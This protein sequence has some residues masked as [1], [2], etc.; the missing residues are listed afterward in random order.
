MRRY[1]L[2]VLAV[3]AV[4]SLACGGS[5]SPK[6]TATPRPTATNTPTPAPPTA[7]PV[8]L[9]PVDQLRADI[10][11][12]LGDS[13]RDVPRITKLIAGNE[14]YIEWTI[15]DNLASLLQSSIRL[16]V[17]NMLEVI[18]HSAVPYKTVNL[19][20]SFPLKDVYGNVSE[21]IVL[22]AVYTAE[23]IGRINWEGFQFKNM[24]EVAETWDMHPAMN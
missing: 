3:L 1:I 9:A 8:P 17:R 5:G 4:A 2:I 22:D 23:A 20:G 7:T 11:D 19:R 24:H 15:S 13:N 18:A 14:I 6:A 16:D 10:L 12:A 21:E